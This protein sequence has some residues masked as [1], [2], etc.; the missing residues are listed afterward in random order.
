MPKFAAQVVFRDRRSV[1][2]SR[3]VPSMFGTRT[4]QV[5]TTQVQVSRF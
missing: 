4:L 2:D 1:N 5:V 3:F